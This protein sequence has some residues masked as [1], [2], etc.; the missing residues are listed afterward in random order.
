MSSTSLDEQAQKKLEEALKKYFEEKSSFKNFSLY[1][2]ES[3]LWLNEQG[4]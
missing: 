3:T 4:K 2:K 1:M